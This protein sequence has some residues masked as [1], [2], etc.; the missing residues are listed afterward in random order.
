MNVEEWCENDISILW[1]AACC[2]AA[3]VVIFENKV[4]IHSF[5]ELF[6]QKVT[7]EFIAGIVLIPL[8]MVKRLFS[9]RG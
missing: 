9:R 1:L 4:V 6:L 3:G 8:A 5:G 2:W 7:L